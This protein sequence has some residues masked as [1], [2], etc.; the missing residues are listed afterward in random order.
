MRPRTPYHPGDT[1]ETYGKFRP[2]RP[3]G[4]LSP[5]LRSTR[6]GAPAPRTGRWPPPGSDPA[7]LR[8]SPPPGQRPGPHPPT[9]FEL[10]YLRL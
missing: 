4:W 9:C 5:H 2:G 7:A 10:M 8:R 1:A 3:E 6:P